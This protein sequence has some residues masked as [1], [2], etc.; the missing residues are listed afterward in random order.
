MRDFIIA[1]LIGVAVLICWRM[2]TSTYLWE[3]EKKPC[4]GVT[5][6][7]TSVSSVPREGAEAD[8]SISK[9]PRSFQGGRS[10]MP[11]DEGDNVLALFQ[12]LCDAIA[13]KDEGRIYGLMDA[14]LGFGPK[15]MPREKALQIL[16]EMLFYGSA[17]ERRYAAIFLAQMGT[18]KAV[19]DIVEAWKKE[20]DEEVRK[21]LGNALA[22]IKNPEAIS[23]LGYLLKNE[24]SMKLISYVAKALV[25]IGTD[26]AIQILMEKGKEAEDQETIK[27]IAIALSG[28]REPEKIP[29]SIWAYLLK[30]QKDPYAVKKITNALIN[31]GTEKAV[32]ALIDAM[33]TADDVQRDD[34]GFALARLKGKASISVLRDA[35]LNHPNPKVREYAAIALAQVGGKE[36]MPLLEKVLLNDSSEE[37]RTAAATAIAKMLGSR[38]K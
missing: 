14:F 21:E 1:I 24:D 17:D 16:E 37:V 22:M 33:E 2:F 5:S 30:A 9:I 28:T 3:P 15:R 19:M 38:Q 27:T 36:Q 32:R 18:E 34:I 6:P 10:S 8:V 25:R 4:S 11:S 7:E 12:Q 31:M 29:V 23:Y 13:Q 20:A 35:V 26:E